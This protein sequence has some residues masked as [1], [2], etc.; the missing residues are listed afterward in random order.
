L[1]VAV[2]GQ[3][4]SYDLP[5]IH[6]YPGR[7]GDLVAILVGIEAE[8]PGR[9][10]AP[11]KTLSVYVSAFLHTAVQEVQIRGNIKVIS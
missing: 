1:S 2:I 11:Y 7:A 4:S 5:A 6:E 3:V 8:A 9:S 10:I